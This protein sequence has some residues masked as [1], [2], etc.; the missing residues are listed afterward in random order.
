M[1]SRGGCL[2]GAVRFVIT[3]RLREVVACHCGQCQKVHGT[4]GAY[5]ACALDRLRFEKDA[6][7]AWYASSQRATRGFCRI[8]GSSLFWRPV[9]QGTVSVA[10]GVLD[11]AGDLKLARHIFTADKPDWYAITDGLEEIEHSMTGM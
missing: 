4:F 2:C 8:C 5:T 3:G 9:G 11:D 10:A 6:G 1:E 7:L